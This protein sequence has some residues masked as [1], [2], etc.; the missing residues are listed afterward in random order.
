[1]PAQQRSE[2]CS[3][4]E[5]DGY[6]FVPGISSHRCQSIFEGFSDFNTRGSTRH[7]EPSEKQKELLTEICSPLVD[8]LKSRDFRP[9]RILFFEKSVQNN[10]FVPW[11]QDRTI[12]VKE[13]HE[14]Q[15]YSRW[16]TKDGTPHV[17]PPS[18][19]LSRM[20]TMRI[21]LDAMTADNG[22]L[23]VAPRSHCLGRLEQ[24]KVMKS[25]E[26]GNPM[27]LTCD[28]GDILLM[29]PLLLHASSRSTSH[30]P[31]RILHVELS[32]DSL[33]PP[34]EWAI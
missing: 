11:H 29:K 24:D 4:L 21:H 31:R 6:T 23:I 9:V 1:M 5:N 20:V 34:L 3:A 17:E 8:L 19:L 16:T 7:I 25:V 10:W 12:A 13:R 22:N 14:I 28:A 26:D 15:G 32:P 30:M 33:P 18:E 2:I 27:P